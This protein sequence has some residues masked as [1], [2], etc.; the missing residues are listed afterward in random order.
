M[1][2]YVLFGQRKEN[3]DGQYGPE[4]LAICD[5]F[6]YD[7][8]AFGD[9]EHPF[10]KDCRETQEKLKGEFQAMRLLGV[11]VDQDYIREQLVGP[12]KLKG[13]VLGQG[14]D[15]TKLLHHLRR[16]VRHAM[17]PEQHP[18]PD[19]ED[20]E[21]T[22]EILRSLDALIGAE[23]VPDPFREPIPED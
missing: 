2:L 18:N 6:V 4:A 17:N 1:L 16:Y 14:S 11:N 22:I 9:E 3:Y 7:E 15:P 23:Q 10:D 12:P 20:S 5:E 19:R 8:A 21:R 13:Y